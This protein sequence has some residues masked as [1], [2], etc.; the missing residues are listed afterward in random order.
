MRKMRPASWSKIIRPLFNADSPNVP[1][2]SV[3]TSLP[4]M[5]T[6]DMTSPTTSDRQLSKFGKRTKM[7]L[8]AALGRILVAQRFACPTSWWPSCFALKCNAVVSKASSN[9]ST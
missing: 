5:A 7:P 2:T 6:A 3:P 1:R 4:A 8:A 9:F